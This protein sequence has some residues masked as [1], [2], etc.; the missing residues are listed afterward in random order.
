MDHYLSHDAQLE[1]D[2][3]QSHRLV[4]LLQP[5]ENKSLYMKL[6]L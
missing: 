1:E 2:E 4:E 6:G 3:E 5:D